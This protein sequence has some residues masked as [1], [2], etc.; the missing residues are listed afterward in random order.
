[1]TEHCISC[2]KTHDS[3][4][5]RSRV[6]SGKVVYICRDRASTIIGDTRSED[7]KELANDLKTAPLSERPRIREAMRTIRNESGSIK[8]MRE[9]LIREKLRG[10]LDNIKDIHTYIQGKEQYGR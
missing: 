1:M 6:L 7:L 3:L 10:N 4:N 9:S 5:W 2:E 8:S